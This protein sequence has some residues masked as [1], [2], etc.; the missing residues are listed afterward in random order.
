MM[1]GLAM[2]SMSSVA[3]VATAEAGRPTLVFAGHE[4]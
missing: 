4:L 1:A 3:R 2:A